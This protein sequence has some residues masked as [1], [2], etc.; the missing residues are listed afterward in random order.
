MGTYGERGE[1][2]FIPV[3]IGVFLG[4]GFVYSAD[5][6]ISSLGISSPMDLVDIKKQD[7]E[8]A[9]PP[10]PGQESLNLSNGLH[11]DSEVRQRYKAQ[12]PEDPMLYL[13]TQTNLQHQSQV[14][15]GLTFYFIEFYFI[16][17]TSGCKLE[18]NSA[19]DRGRHHSQYSRGF[20]CR[21]GFRC[22]REI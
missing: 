9:C 15:P 5:L 16:Q 3:S 13:N 12:P 8:S 11:T 22:C 17:M 19:V 21:G 18:K 6:L 4:A 10:P 2:A 7:S 14:E 20:G 1:W